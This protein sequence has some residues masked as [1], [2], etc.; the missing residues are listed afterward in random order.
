MAQ[1]G[2]TAQEVAASVGPNNEVEDAANAAAE[3]AGVRSAAFVD[4]AEAL[5]AYEDRSDV[6]NMA[7]RLTREIGPDFAA[8]DWARES[9]VFAT[10]AATYVDVDPAGSGAEDVNVGEGPVDTWPPA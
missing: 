7:T 4:Y 8:A 3:A 5:A 10:G 6:E 9:G 2:K 1:T